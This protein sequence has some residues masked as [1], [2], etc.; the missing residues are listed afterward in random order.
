MSCSAARVNLLSAGWLRR[1][2]NRGCSMAKEMTKLCGNLK[3]SEE[4]E[5]KVK[6]PTSDIEEIER[7]VDLYLIGELLMEKAFNKEA[8]RRT[9]TS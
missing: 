7:D 3:L 4:E 1:R 8:F 2:V 6:L 9:L 5:N